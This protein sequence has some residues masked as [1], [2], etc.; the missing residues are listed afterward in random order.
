LAVIFFAWY[1]WCRK[2]ETIKQTPAVVSGLTEK[3]WT[4]GESPETTATL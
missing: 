4:F 2:H 1:N 3:V